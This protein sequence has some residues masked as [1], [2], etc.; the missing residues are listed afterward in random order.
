MIFIAIW[1][2]DGMQIEHDT[3]SSIIKLKVLI[4][5]QQYNI[6]TDNQDNKIIDQISKFPQDMTTN[7]NQY[8][9]QDYQYAIYV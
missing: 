8:H 9:T 4:V 6:I 3:V 5:E 2:R 7:M 1:L